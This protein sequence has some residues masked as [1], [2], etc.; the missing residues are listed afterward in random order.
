VG[1]GL[2]INYKK[3]TEPKKL[4]PSVIHPLRCSIDAQAAPYFPGGHAELTLVI[5]SN[6][7]INHGPNMRAAPIAFG[8]SP[9]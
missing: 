1:I 6:S 4:C 2:S 8:D 3:K 7:F 5:K 9:S